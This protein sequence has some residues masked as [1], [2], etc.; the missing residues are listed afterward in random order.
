MKVILFEEIAGV[1]KAGAI[2]DV[3]VGFARNFVIGC[4]KGAAATPEALREHKRREEEAE[5]KKQAEQNQQAIIADKLNGSRVR[6]SAKAKNGV[7]FGSV[8]KK[9]IAAAIVEQTNVKDVTAKMIVLN[10]QMKK[11][12]DYVITVL[13]GKDHSADVIV[14]IVEE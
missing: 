8:D 10:T 2:V 1:G 13:F 3:S 14:T 4:K 12:G 11:T 7:L 5:R 6:V 9:A